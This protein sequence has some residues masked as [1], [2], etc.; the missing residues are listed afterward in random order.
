MDRRAEIGREDDGDGEAIE[1]RRDP[2]RNQTDLER[3]IRDGRLLA[4][5]TGDFTWMKWMS[6]PSIFVLNWGNRLSFRS[7]SRQSYFEAQYS[8]TSWT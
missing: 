4:V 3:G 1:A 6:S 8:Q 2:E 7:R 5:A